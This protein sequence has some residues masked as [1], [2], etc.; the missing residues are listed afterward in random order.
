MRTETA[1]MRINH[2]ILWL[3]DILTTIG[4]ILVFIRWSKHKAYGDDAGCLA[5]FKRCYYVY[6]Y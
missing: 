3:I 1:H 5:D 2:S 4:C 6:Y